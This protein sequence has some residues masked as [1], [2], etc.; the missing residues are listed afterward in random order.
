MSII[1]YA[2]QKLAECNQSERWK[3]VL[4]WMAFLDGANATNTETVSEESII[5]KLHG[6]SDEEIEEMIR[7][8]RAAAESLEDYLSERKAEI[9]C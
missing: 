6:M 8:A 3:D 2:K 1:E 9:P 4:Y 7:S 5:E